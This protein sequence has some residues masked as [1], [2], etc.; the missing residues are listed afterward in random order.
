LELFKGSF[1]LAVLG[2][3]NCRRVTLREASR[4]FNSPTATAT[5][6]RPTVSCRCKSGCSTKRCKCLAA[7]TYCLTTCHSGKS[8][9]NGQDEHQEAVGTGMQSPA[10]DTQV[11]P[12]GKLTDDVITSACSLLLLDC[13]GYS[14]LQPPSVLKV[15]GQVDTA[16]GIC[17]QVHNINDSHW[18][19]SFFPGGNLGEC[20]VFDSLPVGAAIPGDLCRQLKEMYSAGPNL[21]LRVQ[22]YTL[23]KQE[24]GDACGFFAL[25]FAV[26][27][28]LLGNC[29]TLDDVCAS[30]IGMPFDQNLMRSHLIQCL[31]KA[32]MTHFPRMAT[33]SSWRPQRT[34]FYLNWR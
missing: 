5:A 16:V 11:V 25:A 13:P 12:E 19:C 6:A 31:K 18:V 15:P 1:D 10:A 22:Y 32:E 27:L 2:W 3:E 23:Q 24:G 33:P 17:V 8:C 21:P 29:W 4:V 14:G 28:A 30:F 20:C 9:C 7:G 26:E 34:T